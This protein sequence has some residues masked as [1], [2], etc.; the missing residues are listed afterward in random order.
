MGELL[1]KEGAGQTWDAS[2]GWHGDSIADFKITDNWAGYSIG[3]DQSMT[4]G[5]YDKFV[6]DIVHTRL[7]ESFLGSRGDRDLRNE[8]NKLDSSEYIKKSIDGNSISHFFIDNVQTVDNTL[9]ASLSQP[10]GYYSAFGR[11]QGNTIKADSPFFTSYGSGS[12]K[13]RLMTFLLKNGET[14]DGGSFG[15]DG[16]W[17]GFPSPNRDAPWKEHQATPGLDFL[18]KPLDYLI[19]DGCIVNTDAN[20]LIITKNLSDWKVFPQF[21]MGTVIHEDW[22]ALRGYYGH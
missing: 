7:A 6:V 9:S 1:L 11:V 17:S 20:Q 5:E 8:Y 14:I 10:T 19:S 15:A 2:N 22:S 18:E 13:F 21:N 12:S 4:N 16:N 3:F